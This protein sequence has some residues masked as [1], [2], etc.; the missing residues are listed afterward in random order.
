MLVIGCLILQKREDGGAVSGRFGIFFAAE[1]R[2]IG[3]NMKI[4]NLT[5]HQATDAQMK[6]GVFNANQS[7]NDLLTF[8]TAPSEQEMVERAEKLADIAA[9]AK[10]EAAM[11]GGAGYFMR[12]LEEAL[13]ARGIRPLYSFSERRSVEKHNPDGTVVKTNVFEHVGWVG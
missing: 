2:R 10:A 4:I 8:I 9:E 6:E 3:D 13:R 1:N 7:L 12:P 11:I 5:Q